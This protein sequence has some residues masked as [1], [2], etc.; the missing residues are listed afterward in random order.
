[1][2]QIS[3]ISI[4]LA[5]NWSTF[6]DNIVSSEVEKYSLPFTKDSISFFISVSC[7]LV[8]LYSN[9]ITQFILRWV[10]WELLITAFSANW[11]FGIVANDLSKRLTTVDLNPIDSTV[12]SITPST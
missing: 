12:P 3:F 5:A 7:L 8:V 11:K 9:P 4:E 1:M 6:T 2:K 10:I